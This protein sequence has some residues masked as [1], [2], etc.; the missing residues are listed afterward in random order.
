MQY[1]LI[2]LSA[3]GAKTGGRGSRVPGVRG[4]HSLRWNGIRRDEGPLDGDAA[5]E[6]GADGSGV[7][8]AVGGDVGDVAIEEGDEAAR[9]VPLV[10][11]AG[12]AA[13]AVDVGGVGLGRSVRVG[14]VGPADAAAVLVDRAEGPGLGAVGG[15]E[16]V[17]G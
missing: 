11:H 7:H 15:E 16:G 17:G 4:G 3:A 9:A 12:A 5:V 14:G 10:T 8:E 6:A 2:G 1:H 13:V